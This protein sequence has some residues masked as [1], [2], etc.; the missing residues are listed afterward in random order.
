MF[1]FSVWL[2]N[3]PDEALIH[4][5]SYFLQYM[6]IFLNLTFDILKAKTTTETNGN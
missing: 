3:L 2:K 4:I 1:S 6:L 5:Y